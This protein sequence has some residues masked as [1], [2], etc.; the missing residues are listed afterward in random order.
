MI[1]LLIT[2]VEELRG[3]LRALILYFEQVCGDEQHREALRSEISLLKRQAATAVHELKNVT[4][5][6]SSIE[7]LEK[8]KRKIHQE[9][10][11]RLE[12]RVRELK[13]RSIPSKKRSGEQKRM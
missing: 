1:N 6:A 9:E 11:T 2:R 3:E 7:D 4:A 5:Q 10:I 13:E 8:L 12:N